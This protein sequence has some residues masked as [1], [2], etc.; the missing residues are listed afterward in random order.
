MNLLSKYAGKFS[1][2]DHSDDDAE[3]YQKIAE[4]AHKHLTSTGG[5]EAEIDHESVLDKHKKIYESGNVTEHSDEELGHAAAFEAL[6][7]M[8]SSGSYDK[9]ELLSLAMSEGMK[10]WEKRQSS[11][12]SSDGGKAVV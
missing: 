9:S 6:K 1:L 12:G 3:K 4:K 8:C 5:H 2:P 11:G 7:K 10:L